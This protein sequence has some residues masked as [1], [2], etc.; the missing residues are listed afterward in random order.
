MVI[1]RRWLVIARTQ[2]EAIHRGAEM[3][4]NTTVQNSEYLKRLP[5]NWKLCAFNEIVQDCSAGNKK[6]LTSDFL[7]EGKYIVV[8]QGK[9]LVAGYTN[10]NSL[11]VKTKPPYVIFGDHTRIFKYIDL[12]FAMGADGTKV[13]KP[14]QEGFLIEKFLYYYFLTLN[15]PNTGYNRH[16]KFLK[17]IDIPLPPLAEQEKIA[18]ILDA[19]DDLRQK[20]Q[21]LIDHYTALGQAVF[22]D[23]FGDPVTNP[24]GWELISLGEV[25]S[26]SSG[27][28]PS[29][30]IDEYYEGNIPWVKTGEVCGGTIVSTSEHISENALKTSSCKIYPIGSLIIAMYGQGKTRGQVAKLGI[31]AT[32]NQ[33]CAVI[34]PSDKMNYE[35]LF[36]LLKTLYEDLRSLGRGGNQPNLNSGLLK[37]YKVLNPPLHLQNQFAERIAHIEA[38]KQQAVASLAH[39][40][41]LFDSLLHRAFTG[42]LT[43]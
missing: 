30:E 32:T 35:F 12:P 22:I 9:N 15:I 10:D 34:S 16:F 23:M 27:S 8:D 38:Q 42:E 43:Q 3:S 41:A 40:Q 26:I 24:M 39:S 7:S 2:S 29:R 14:K 20:D 4:G 25:G 5:E 11:L 1:A 36:E 13:L 28:T 6:T 37:S 17:E 19:A 18:Q 21:Q 33:A 31:P